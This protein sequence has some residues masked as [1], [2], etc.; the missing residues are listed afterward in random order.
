MQFAYY[1]CSKL[2][3]FSIHKEKIVSICV[4]VLLF[5]IWLTDQART[6]NLKVALYYVCLH[7][8][9]TEIYLTKVLTFYKSIVHNAW[10]VATRVLMHVCRHACM[11]LNKNF[12]SMLAS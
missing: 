4:N 9:F 5:T 7:A 3:I 10:G 11:L 8:N 6:P 1:I 2:L 12:I